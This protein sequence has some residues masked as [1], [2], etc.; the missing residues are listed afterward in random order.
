MFLS[1]FSPTEEVGGGRGKPD[2]SIPRIFRGKIG[3]FSSSRGYVLGVGA[4]EKLARLSF[5]TAG[6][7]GLYAPLFLPSIF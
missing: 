7:Q 5:F 4:K 1:S 2:S 3:T 6:D